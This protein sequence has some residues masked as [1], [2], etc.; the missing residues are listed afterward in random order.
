[1]HVIDS[2]GYN[3]ANLS[4]VGT[5]DSAVIRYGQSVLQITIATVKKMNS[6]SLSVASAIIGDTVIN[7]CP[8]N[9][10]IRQISKPSRTKEL[11]LSSSALS[12]GD[13]RISYNLGPYSKGAE[14]LICTPRGVCIRKL[15]LSKTSGV[16]TWDGRDKNGFALPGG[17]YLSI[18]SAEGK[19]VASAALRR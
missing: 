15:P 1:M 6:C 3:T 13:V 4:V 18:L 5:C 10:V 16:V 7:L 17:M 9:P 8:A 11:S 19:M 2:L 12:G 14:V